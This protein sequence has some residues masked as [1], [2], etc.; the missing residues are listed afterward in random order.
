MYVRTMDVLE[1]LTTLGEG[2]PPSP[3]SPGPSPSL[4]PPLPMHDLA[5]DV[6]GYFLEESSLWPS[7]AKFP[8]HFSSGHFSQR[9]QEGGGLSLDP[10]TPPPLPNPPPNFLIPAECS[11]PLLFE[12]N[13]PQPRSGRRSAMFCSQ[14]I[15][16]VVTYSREC[17]DDTLDRF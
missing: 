16:R 12:T 1:S 3:Q 15:E 9:R 2:P 7:V 10:L 6:Q 5:R 17:P 11:Y 4:A 13:Q 14:G 8:R